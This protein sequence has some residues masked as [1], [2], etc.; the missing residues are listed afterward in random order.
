MKHKILGCDVAKNTVDCCLY[1]CD[2][3]KDVNLAS[4]WPNSEKGFK[5]LMM[6]LG[7]YGGPA[8]V[9]IVMEAT[10]IYHENMV[11]SFHDNGYDVYVALPNQVKNYVRSMGTRAKTDRIDAA[12]I[13]HFGAKI[14]NGPTCINIFKWE[15]WSSTLNEIKLLIRQFCSFQDSITIAKNRREAHSCTGRT[16]MFINQQDANLIK[17]L[18][19][20]RDDCKKRIISLAQADTAL[21]NK[22]VKICTIKGVAELTAITIVAET[23]GFALIRNAR[24]LTSYAGLDVPPYES[25]LCSKP[26]HISHM[27]NSFIRRALY[28]PALSVVRH[29]H[30]AL[31]AFYQRLAERAGV[32]HHKKAIIALMRK[33]LCL[34]YT[35]WKKNEEYDPNHQWQRTEQ[36]EKEHPLTPQV[37]ATGDRE[38]VP[39][40][41]PAAAAAE[42]KEKEEHSKECSS[43]DSDGPIGRTPFHSPHKSTTFIN[44]IPNFLMETFGN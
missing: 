6:K 42:P 44:N 2:S 30:G 27:G 21:W 15:P 34:I 37:T 31:Q 8:Q 38:D 18:T 3:H 22:I 40:I 24:Q 11:D 1:D 7:K 23:N 41:V 12:S 25:G 32:G 14:G 33:L 17:Y 28:M 26:G 29:D 39:S 4:K 13:A 35:L 19:Q 20:Q 16:P 10:G 5:N 43:R 9:D 36:K